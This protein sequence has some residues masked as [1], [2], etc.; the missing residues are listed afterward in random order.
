MMHKQLTL[1]TLIFFSVSLLFGISVGTPLRAG[2]NVPLTTHQYEEDFDFLWKEMADSYAYFDQKQTDWQQVKRRYRPQTS[3]VTNRA[4]FI[5]LLERTLEELYDFHCNLN[6]NTESSPVL[7]PTDADLWAEWRQGHAFITEVR[8]DSPA[9]RAGIRTGME[10]ISINGTPVRQAVDA[11][12]GFCLRHKDIKALNWS[13]QT[14]LA[15]RHNETRR[16][17]FREE[18]RVSTKTLPIYKRFQATGKTS[19]DLLESRTLTQNPQ[20]GYIRLHNSLGETSLSVAFDKALEGLKSTQGLILDLRDTPSGGSSTVARA[21]MGRFI[22]QTMF[23]QRHSVPAEERVYGVKRSWI[24]EVSPRGTFCYTGA[25]VVLVDHWT[26][27]MGEG[28]T[29][30]MDAMNRARI[31]GTKMARLLGATEGILLP[32][33]HIQVHFPTEK[34]FHVNRK[35][36]EAFIPPVSVNLLSSS[37]QQME[38]P[39]LRAGIETLSRSLKRRVR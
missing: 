13:L 28:L 26:G 18:K 33:S 7:V 16:I 34:L 35:P 37:S 8:P 5:G 1:K 25:V 30:G 17:A 29:I 38:D 24:E 32:N 4:E 23:Y 2:Q 39:I 10:V 3:T 15:G 9:R 19:P 14:L 31:V 11:R 20:L 22:S 6:T 36:R 12:I 27:S 21:I